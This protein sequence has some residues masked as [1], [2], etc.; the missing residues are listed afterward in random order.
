MGLVV[1]A[2]PIQVVFEARKGSFPLV[3]EGQASA[4][5][6]EEGEA[7]VV[8]TAVE[9]LR[10]DVMMVSGVDMAACAVPRYRGRN[11]IVG[12]VNQSHWIDSLAREK[13]IDVGPVVGQWETFGIAVVDPCTLAVYGSDARGTAYGLMELSRMMGVSP[14][15]YWADVSPR[16]HPVICVTRGESVYGPPSVK[17]RGI[18]IND[19]DWG[20][21]PWA[22]THLDKAVNDI[23]PRTYEKVFELLLRLK[24]NTIWPAMHPCTKAFWYYKEC[25]ELARKF[26]IILGSSHCEQMGR[27]NVDEWVHNF[28]FEFGRLPGPYSWKE[29]SATI[30][31]YWDARVKESRGTEMIYTLGMRGIHDSGLP[32]YAT[33]EE[34]RDALKEIIGEQRR[35]IEQRMG[36]PAKEVPQTFCPYKEALKLYR[37]RL[38]LPDDITLLWVDDNFGYI[39]QLSTPEEQQRK[40]GAGVYYHFSYWG[41]PQDYLWLGATPP[42]LMAYEMMKAY[43]TNCRDLWIFNVGDIKPME[44]E[45]QYALDFAWDIRTLD[46]ANA[47]LY[48]KSWAKEIFGAE[49]AE[50][51]YEIKRE[52]GRL[53]QGGKPEHVNFVDYTVDEGLQRLMDYQ[54]LVKKVENTQQH[55]PAGRRDAY[56]ELI[57]YPVKACAAMNEKVLGSKLSY[58]YARCGYMEETNK[59][60]ELCRQ[61]FEKVVSLT[62]QYNHCVA[63][64]KWSGMMDYAPRGLRHFKAFEAAQEKD[65]ERGRKPLNKY[66]AVKVGAGAYVKSHGENVKRI[67]G[68]GI[69]GESV[70]VWPL[71]MTMYQKASE[72]P[73]VEYRLPV[74]KGRNEV[75]VKCLPTF[76]LYQGLKLRYAISIAE[77]S[78]E[79]IDF[80]TEAETKQW[81]PNVLRGYACGVT[82]YVSSSDQEVAIRIYFMDPCVVL[83]EI[84]VRQY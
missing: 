4:L 77:N 27:N 17:H 7:E 66:D 6:V 61:G 10:G 49:V 65:V 29:N 67:S 52:Y 3:M 71:D 63:G 45:M 46:M 48:A 20:L 13:R 5:V 69:S 41:V 24:A 2:K 38:D 33:D 83:E 42:A 34:R 47:D 81:S 84:E 11:V 60:A 8:K 15:H 53:S 39:R 28:P 59:Y 80:Q 82:E 76:P 64:G 79:T 23:G 75:V 21:Q 51:I 50:D 43:E 54:A 78:P 74:K 57:A 44:Y 16:Q 40:G 72:A 32:G 30:K 37:L 70:A 9:L 36:K 25:P 62:H 73:Y 58:E 26:G 18:F 35:M 12:T 56:F 14:W 22:A 55:I 31:A 68:L 19:E 1:M